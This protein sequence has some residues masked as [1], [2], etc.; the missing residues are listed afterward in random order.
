MKNDEIYQEKIKKEL[1]FFRLNEEFFLTPSA[2]KSFVGISSA[3]TIS[4][5]LPTVMAVKR[6]ARFYHPKLVTEIT[7]NYSMK[8]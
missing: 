3:T 7:K 6:D 8:G 1:A 4:K 2:M 5:P